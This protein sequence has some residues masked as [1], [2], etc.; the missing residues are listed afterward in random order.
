[1]PRTPRAGDP[2]PDLL[3]SMLEHRQPKMINVYFQRINQDES[4]DLF[5]EFATDDVAAAENYCDIRN[6]NLA[7]AGVPTAVA[8]YY[9]I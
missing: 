6:H 9:A 7:L 4:I 3:L 5:L 1:M 8:Y 2:G